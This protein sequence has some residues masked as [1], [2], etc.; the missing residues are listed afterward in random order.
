MCAVVSHTQPTNNLYYSCGRVSY[1]QK[2]KQKQKQKSKREVKLGEVRFVKNVR[3]VQ[4]LFG[5]KDGKEK[6][7]MVLKILAWVLR[8]CWGAAKITFRWSSQLNN[9]DLFFQQERN[10]SIILFLSVLNF[11]LSSLSKKINAQFELHFSS[12]QT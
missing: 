2:Q 7:K 6:I 4:T 9:E 10:I 1:N 8:G 3:A 5:L 11:L 12:F